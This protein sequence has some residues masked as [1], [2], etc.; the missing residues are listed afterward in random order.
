MLS[1][2]LPALAQHKEQTMKYLAIIYNPFGAALP[3]DVDLEPPCRSH[4]TSF[5]SG[6]QL[7]PVAIKV[8]L[9]V[10]P[11]ELAKAVKPWLKNLKDELGFNDFVTDIEKP[12]AA[13]MTAEQAILVINCLSTE[14]DLD[15]FCDSLDEKV[16]QAEDKRRKLLK[17]LNNNGD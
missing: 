12:R 4:V 14:D 3:N 7:V 8:G 10:I 1:A 9:N 15:L 13:D 6:D 11:L 17:R 16:K 5:R 2:A